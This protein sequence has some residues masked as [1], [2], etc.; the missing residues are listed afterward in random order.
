MFLYGFGMLEFTVVCHRRLT[1]K[2]V[3]LGLGKRKIICA[4]RCLSLLDSANACLVH[5]TTVQSWWRA[6]SPIVFKVFNTTFS[7]LTLKSL[8]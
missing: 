2:R 6:A 7:I 8:N 3:S 4:R 5:D 1:T